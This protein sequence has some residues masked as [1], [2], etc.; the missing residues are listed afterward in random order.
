MPAYAAL[1]HAPGS[2]SLAPNHSESMKTTRPIRPA[3][4]F[5]LVELLVVIAIIAVLAAMGFAGAQA[6]INKA[7]KTKAR[8]ICVTLDQAVMSFYN[9]YGFL[10]TNP[11]P[12]EDARKPSR[13]TLTRA[14]TDRNPARL[15]NRQR[16]PEREEDPLLRGRRSQGRQGRHQV[17]H[18]PAATWSPASSTR[19]VAPTACCSMGTTMTT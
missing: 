3:H 18:P 8:K 11:D 17:R 16:D 14:R 6:A 10:P 7:K 13:P 9:E 2:A 5:T 15:R 1:P 4:G 19:G 12:S